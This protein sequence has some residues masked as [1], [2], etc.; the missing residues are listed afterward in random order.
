[1][2][3]FD[4]T[5]ILHV[6]CL[7]YCFMRV[8]QAELDRI[9][10]HSNL[11]EIRQ[12]KHSN[13]SSG[14]PELLYYVPEIFG[15]RDYGHRVDLGD[16]EVCLDLYSS[17]KKMYSEDIEEFTSFYHNTNAPLTLIRLIYCTDICCM[18]KKYLRELCSR[19]T[20]HNTNI[21]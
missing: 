13:M 15:G 14:K 3:I 9:A 11:H 16:V 18:K 4:E 1:M 8:I 5:N 17:P 10:E 2:N 21:C 19:A 12:Q 6:D 20:I 7:R